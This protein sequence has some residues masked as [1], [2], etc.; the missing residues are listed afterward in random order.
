MSLTLLIDARSVMSC[1]SV[2]SGVRS[3]RSPAP[4][5]RSFVP[6]KSGKRHGSS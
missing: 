6:V 5:K 3:S 1:V 2:E 4:R